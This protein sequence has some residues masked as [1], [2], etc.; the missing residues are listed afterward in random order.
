MVLSFE[1]ELP[2]IIYNGEQTKNLFYQKWLD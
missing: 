2:D 1:A